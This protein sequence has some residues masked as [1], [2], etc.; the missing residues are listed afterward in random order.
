MFFNWVLKN[1]FFPLV[2]NFSKVGLKTV[3]SK[4]G[5]A[6]KET[7]TGRESERVGGVARIHAYNFL[8]QNL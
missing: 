3:C 2:P 1:I 8:P 6:P 7:P 5:G 4:V